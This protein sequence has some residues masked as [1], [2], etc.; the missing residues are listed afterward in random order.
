MPFSLLKH[1]VTIQLSA[2]IIVKYSVG[3]MLA[4]MKI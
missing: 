3:I 2:E 1:I 4:V